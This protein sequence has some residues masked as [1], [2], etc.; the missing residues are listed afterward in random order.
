MT[1][2]EGGEAREAVCVSGGEGLAAEEG[3]TSDGRRHSV[4]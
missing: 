4:F 3:V 2:E 1:V